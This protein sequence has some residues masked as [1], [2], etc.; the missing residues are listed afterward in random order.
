MLKKE[1][2]F[3][4]F[5]L[6]HLLMLLLLFI[7]LWPGSV[8]ADVNKAPRTIDSRC[9]KLV[10]HAN[11]DMI[12]DDVKT[13]VF[14]KYSMPVLKSLSDKRASN[15]HV[16][17]LTR[18][19]P[20]VQYEVNRATVKLP[21]GHVCVVPRVKVRATFTQMSVYLANEL[22]SNPCKLLLIRAHEMEHVHTWKSHMK[23]GLA[24]LKKPLQA[25][26][27]TPREYGS[28]K[29]ADQDLRPW[30]V[31]TIDPKMQQLFKQLM[32]AQAEIDSPASYRTV[33]QQ[34]RACP[35]R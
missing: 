21:N 11:V 10:P 35:A 16:F 22:Q 24:L 27:S 6:T 32:Q 17:G 26:F 20:V 3:S 31:G 14:T 1:N 34:L 15:E 2:R 9:L 7:V 18:G 5:I 29:E 19:K 28:Q 4:H 13:Q 33:L 23:G 12:F 30:V 8:Y 25:A